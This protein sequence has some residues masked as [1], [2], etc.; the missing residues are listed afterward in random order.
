MPK[1]V[2]AHLY[3]DLLN[4]YADRGNIITL[5]KRAKWRGI[6]LEVRRYT[7]DD[8][9]NF[10]EVDMVFIGGGSDREQELVGKR[11]L[12]YKDD[13]TYYAEDGGVI[14]AIC[15]GFQLLGHY[16]KMGNV[17]IEGLSLLDIYTEAGST[18]LIGN[19]IVKSPMFSTPIVGFENHA[20]R[21][22]INDH[23]PMG[24]IIHGHGNNG[25]D[26][27]EGVMCK[28]I[29]GTYLHGPL[30]PKNPQL[31]DYYLEQAVRRSDPEYDIEPLDDELENMANRNIVLTYAKKRHH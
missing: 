26:K 25:K 30:F 7:L 19:V 4:L 3:P 31:C 20:G 24:K 17:K 11:L 18:R 1:V 29:L 15:G 22:Y 9:I 6:D 27:T 14:I 28:N 13:I 2:L 16:Y 10:N 21:T 8:D 5:Q 23:D 12:Q